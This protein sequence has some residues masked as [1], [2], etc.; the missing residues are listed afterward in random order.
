MCLRISEACEGKNIILLE[1]EKDCNNFA[2]IEHG[3]PGYAGN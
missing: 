1:G 2:E 3:Q